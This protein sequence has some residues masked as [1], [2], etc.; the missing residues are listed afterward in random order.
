MVIERGLVQF[1]SAGISR[2]GSSTD[3]LSAIRGGSAGRVEKSLQLARKKE[4]EDVIPRRN[5]A[6][7]D[8]TADGKRNH[9]INGQTAKI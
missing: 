6:G 2:P 9:N 7:P 3:G 4:P 1:E 5:S 8:I